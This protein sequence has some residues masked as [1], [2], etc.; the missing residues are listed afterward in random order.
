M[1]EILRYVTLDVGG[2]PSVVLDL[3]DGANFLV[4]RE[5]FIVTFG[6]GGKQAVVSAA[7]RRYGGEKQHGETTPNGQVTWTAM[8]TGASA[9]GAIANVEAMLAQLETIP[10]SL[11]L[12]WRPD[13]ASQSAYYDV[14]G[15]GSWTPK[16]KWVEFAGAQMM[17]FDVSIPVAPL[18]RG[19][20]LDILDLFAV[21]TRSDYTY[22]AGLQ[23]NEEVAGGALKCAANPNN[24][25]IAR[26]TARGYQYGDNQQ[27][28]KYAPK[29]TI[30]GWKG[31]GAVKAIDATNRLEAYVEDNGTNSILKIDK[32]VAGART[33]LATTNLVARVASGVFYWVRGRIEGNVVTAEYFTAAPTP[34]GAPIS[35][36]NYTLAAGA[37]RTTF[38]EAVKGYACRIWT[39]K[40]VGAELDEYAVAPYTYRN[41]SLPAL[42]SLGGT[43]P[44]D[45][46]ARADVTVTPSGGAAAPIWAHLAWGK[47]PAA[48]LAQAPFGIIEAETA[49]NLSGWASTANANSRGGT[50]LKDAAALSTDVYTASYEVDPSLLAADA[51]QTEVAVEVFARVMMDS[52][53]VTPTLTLS[54]RPQDGT[55]Y[56]AARYTDEW[57]SAGK[58]LTVPASGTEK[59]RMVR[60]G[61]LRMLVDATRPR[62]WLLWLA[63]A[64]GAGSSGAWGV[65]YLVLVPAT[66]RAC[67][68]T[69]KAND[70]G[71]PQF[72]ASTA[73]TSKQVKADLSATTAKPPAYGH[74]DHGLGG[75]LIE[76]PGGVEN[77]LLVKLSSLVPDDPTSDATSEQLAHTATVHVA[78]TPRWQLLR[79]GS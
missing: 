24:E 48:G 10:Q 7:D 38:G 20:P 41:Q 3:E 19:L 6:Q 79:S 4:A 36:I 30:T 44:G 8:V 71:Y 29:A 62:V 54:T 23:A 53:I 37:E 42:L 59:F 17:M 49:G 14:R 77:Q 74:P 13:G 69:S 9:D 22:D 68:P 72:V 40:T 66:Q 73:E 56:G 61:T 67:G 32:V 58:L 39:P 64:V 70:S 78:V 46:P 12:E 25:Q 55:N 15:T 57:G 51:F 35:T 52:T 63:G 5:S 34:M 27:T 21:D 50:M 1:S 60:L 26:H 18:A 43:V 76:P 47:K 11:L 31:G 75:Q 28:W 45:G 2:R 65:D 33:N 16:Y